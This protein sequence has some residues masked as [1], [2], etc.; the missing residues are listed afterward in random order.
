MRSKLCMLFFLYTLASSAQ[1]EASTWYFGHNAGLKFLSDG[2]VLPLSD[3][4]LYTD[5]GC[6]TISDANGNLLFYTDG[7]TV[8][9]RNHVVMPNGNYFEG[10]GL[11]GD[12]SS[13]QSGIIIPRPNYTNQYYIFTVDEPHHE[14]ALVYPAVFSGNYTETGSGNVPNS[15]DGK[16]NGFNY[17]LIDLSINGSNGSLGDVVTR[18][19]H[20]ITY[21]TNPNGEQIKYKCSEK[22]TAVKNENDNSY[23]VITHF[24]NKF[25]AFKV[26]EYGVSTTPVISTIGSNQ[27]LTGYRRNAIGYLK[28]SLT[29]KK[30]LLLINKT[31]LKPDYLPMAQEVWN[32]LILI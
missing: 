17:S 5:E 1:G 22:I 10:T 19:I 7:R 15:D 4:L 11:F 26:D 27:E 18:N 12:P 8:W 30:L 21:D 6:S 20:L 16:N 29:V 2:S 32:F 24:V 23:W 28:A 25:Y 9:D 31:A 3:G 14:N 13:T